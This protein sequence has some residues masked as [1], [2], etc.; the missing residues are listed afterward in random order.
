MQAIKK[1]P[2][3]WVNGLFIRNLQKSIIIFTSGDYPS[4]IRKRQMK[5]GFAK[6]NFLGPGWEVD[7]L[8]RMGR[9]G[10]A[11]GVPGR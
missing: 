3:D 8:A 9:R 5:N 6:S 1:S 4:S 10:N 11:Q 7:L 2:L